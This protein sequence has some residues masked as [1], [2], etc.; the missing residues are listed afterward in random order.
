MTS[1]YLDWYAVLDE[2]IRQFSNAS[3]LAPEGAYLEAPDLDLDQMT[4]RSLES[5]RRVCVDQTTFT[6]GIL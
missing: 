6:G 5:T 3:L 1:W 2:G 4:D